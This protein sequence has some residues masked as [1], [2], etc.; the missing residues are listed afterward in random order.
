MIRQV[1]DGLLPAVAAERLNHGDV[2]G[3]GGGGGGGG[4]DGRVGRKPVQP[5]V[6]S[7]R[8]APL[9][10]QYPKLH[11]QYRANKYIQYIKQVEKP[12]FT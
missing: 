8:S 5:S 6:R 10:R 4:D 12:F 2:G 7:R 3:G 9:H 11:R 1:L